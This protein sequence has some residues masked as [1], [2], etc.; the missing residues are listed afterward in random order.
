[1]KLLFIL[2]TRPDAIKLAP[3][4]QEARK[5]KNIKTY[6]CL[7][8]QHR[9][10]LDQV[11]NFFGIKPDFDLNLMKANQNLSDITSKA[12]S[13]L[14][15]IIKKTKPNWVI[16][17][18]D[19]TTTFVGALCAFY[20]KTK[21]AHVEAGLRTYNKF[22]PFPEEINRALT[23]QLADIHFA[24]TRKAE[25]YLIKENIPKKRIVI[26]GN[27]GIDALFYALDKIKNIPQNKMAKSLKNIDFSSKIILVTG[28][29]RESFGKPFHD[30]CL[31][32][33]QI[34]K[35]F[36]ESNIV[37]PVHLNPN[38]RKPVF[39]ILSKV[40]NIHLIEPLDYPSFVWLMKKSYLILTDSGGIQE[41]A[42]SIKKPVI[43]MRNASERMEG[44][45]A[46][47]A[48]L[49]GTRKSAIVDSVSNLISNKK[50][51]S[52]MIASRN[53]YGDGKASR[54]IIREIV[55]A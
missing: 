54:R 55:N 5:H 41:E 30:I 36:P 16:V 45:E 4:I 21:I 23:T 49:I 20:N 38:V 2:G 43:V 14:G 31:A 46:G 12:T 39:K 29:R 34:A 48:K 11:V 13:K 24:P 44:I 37:Y 25:K 50:L 53:P 9:Q 22:S 35:I 18:G 40:K 1:M 52:G 47:I 42:P 32:L 27:T 26:T 7:T 19:T 6:V 28:H 15:N 17:Q 3:V 8:G 33:K 51:Y 10:L